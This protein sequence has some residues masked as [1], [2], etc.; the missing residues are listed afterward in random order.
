MSANNLRLLGL[1]F[2]AAAL[3]LL[4]AT[5][6]QSGGPVA[7]SV[8][9]GDGGNGA[10]ERLQAMLPS[11]VN[12]GSR[13]RTTPESPRTAAWGTPAV[14]LRC[15]VPRPAELTATSGLV[16]VNDVEWFFEE[17]RPNYVFTAVA[18]EPYVELRVPIGIPREQATAPL[19]DLAP[20]LKRVLPPG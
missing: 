3:L 2:V 13:M 15:G 6:G 9:T 5:R 12:S 1:A 20:A 11:E 7:V 4:V 14:V 19:V 18:R 17:R 10:C 16:V 8:P